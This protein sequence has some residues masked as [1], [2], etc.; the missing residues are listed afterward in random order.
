[1]PAKPSELAIKK[2]LISFKKLIFQIRHKTIRP[3]VIATNRAIVRVG[4]ILTIK[5][6]RIGIILI[7]IIDV[8]GVHQVVE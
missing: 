3:A 5:L 4:Q 8:L 2:V 7:L 1:M 6:I